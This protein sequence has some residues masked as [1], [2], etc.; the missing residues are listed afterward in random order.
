ML[1]YDIIKGNKMKTYKEILTEG[2][3]DKIK[4]NKALKIKNA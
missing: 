2:V 1:L 4:K 3:I